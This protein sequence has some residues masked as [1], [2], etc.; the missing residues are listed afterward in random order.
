MDPL[1]PPASVLIK[2][3]SIARHSEE[4]RGPNGHFLDGT[5]IDSLLQDPEVVEWMEAADEPALLP[6]KR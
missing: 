4:S 1:A 5:A 6:V 3:G 2:L